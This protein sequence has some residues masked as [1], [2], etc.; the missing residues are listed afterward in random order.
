ME[1]QQ[2]KAP[3][4][5]AQR[6]VAANTSHTALQT[7]P[8]QTQPSQQPQQTKPAQQPQWQHLIT[9]TP[10]GTQFPV[11]AKPQPAPVPAANPQQQIAAIPRMGVKLPLGVFTDTQTFRNALDMAKV[12]SRANILPKDFCGNEANTL[13][14]IDLALRLGVSILEISTCVTTLNGKVVWE[15]KYITGKINTSY[16]YVGGVEYEYSGT[17]NTDE[18][19]CRAVVTTREGK[20]QKGPL[21]T[22]KMAKAEGWYNK[23]TR[24]G[25]D[26]VTKWQTMPEMMLS[27]RA[28]SFFSRLYCPE[29]LLGLSM[30]CDN[31]EPDSALEV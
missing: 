5:Q 22:I 13:I 24:D 7:N 18:Y 4:Q 2:A 30:D 20:V 1:Q 16:K 3:V 23:Q 19:G 10:A 26:M 28:V 8:P 9:Q 21:I 12:L 27:Y 15:A 25:K 11:A 14:L 31:V 6:Q 17:P 29:L